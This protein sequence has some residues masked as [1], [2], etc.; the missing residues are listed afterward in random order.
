MGRAE[1]NECNSSIRRSFA[2]PN[3]LYIVGTMNSADKSI[4]LIDTALRRK[5]FFC[6]NKKPDSTLVLD[7]DLKQLLE[8]IERSIGKKI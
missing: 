4:S 5:I 1:P 8:K 3:N 6:R 7:P 2:V